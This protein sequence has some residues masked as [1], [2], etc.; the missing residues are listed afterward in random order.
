MNTLY[1]IT[2]KILKICIYIYIKY[3]GCVKKTG[4]KEMAGWRSHFGKNSEII[5]FG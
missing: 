2:I 5:L 1:L 3:T 4:I